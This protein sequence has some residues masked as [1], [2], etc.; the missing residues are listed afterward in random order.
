MAFNDNKSTGDIIASQ[1]WDDFVDFAELISGNSYGHSSN[2]DI[3]YPSS[4]LLNWLDG[5]YQQSG[6]LGTAWSGAT[7]Y[8]GHSGNQI[9]HHAYAS[10]LEM[11]DPVDGSYSD[12][13]CSWTSDTIVTEALDEVNEILDELAPSDAD[14]VTGTLTDNVTNYTGR[15]VSRSDTT[16]GPY[17]DKE[18]LSSIV[19]IG[20]FDLDAGS[21]DIVF[22]KADE[23]TLKC[24]V[25]GTQS[26]SVNLANAFNSDY[27][28][29]SQIYP[30]STNQLVEVNSVGKYNNFKKWQV[31]SG[32]VGTI[33]VSAGLIMVT[34]I[35]TYLTR[36]YLL[37]YLLVTT[38]VGTIIEEKG[39]HP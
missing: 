23:G 39:M 16:K 8:I 12:G 19:I 33:D 24:Y 10:S 34:I 25:N 22:N 21:T 4:N 29:S 2:R 13:C 11:G 9:I 3:H 36:V 7:G 18:L 26:G 15:V 5:E 38:Y 27:N 28:N 6:T 35:Y 1:D 17:S 37:R 31:V 32:Q 30:P 14:S 20:D